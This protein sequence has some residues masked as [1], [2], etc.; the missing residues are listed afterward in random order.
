MSGKGGTAGL[1]GAS[2]SAGKGGAG[3]AGAG[4]T[5]GKGG[6]AGT[7]GSGQ[8][9]TGGGTSITVNANAR[10]WY[11]SDGS[12]DSTNNNTIT[13]GA[14]SAS[15]AEYRS[16][17]SFPLPNF[18]GTVTAVTLRVEHE[19]YISPQAS[20]TFAIFD[21]LTAAATVEATQSGTAGIAIF[22]DLGMGS[23]YGLFQLS[24]ATVGTIVD[25]PLGSL[26]VSAVGL[27]RGTTFTV[28]IRANSLSAGMVN[29]YAR[30]SEASEVRTHQLVITTTP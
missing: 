14:I 8:G 20:E 6:S 15:F 30:F 4:G 12:H 1:G 19:S 22:N 5:A 23:D 21:V 3:G 16:Y 10:G 18:T 26:G 24:A 13:G 2:G 28:A 27:A 25:V 7:A 9:G 29:E 11:K 17:M